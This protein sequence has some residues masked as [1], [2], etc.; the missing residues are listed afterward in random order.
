MIRISEAV[1]AGHPDKF[2]D[3]VA[4]AVI[5]ACM[6][7]DEDAYGQVEVAAWSDEVWL[8]G[9][10]CTRKP[11]T[12]PIGDIVVE[13][14]QAV[15]YTSGNWVDASRYR[16]TDAICRRVDEP[17][18]WTGKVNDQ[19]VVIGWAGYDE[20]V[21]YL[22]P[23]HFLAQ[24]YRGAMMDSCRN[25]YLEGQ[26]PD[27]KLLVRLKEQSVGWE[28]EHVLVTLQQKE[29]DTFMDLCVAVEKTLEE[30]YGSIRG[31]NPKW[32]KP[33]PEVR[34]MINPNGP[35]INGGSDGDNGQTGRKLAMDFYGPR[36]PIGGG[37]LSGKHLSHIDRIGAY[38]AREAAVR[39]VRSG[40]RE[41]LVRVAYAPNTSEPLD[42]SYQMLGRGERE[43]NAFF[44]LLEMIAR[45]S[46]VRITR[47][48]AEGRHFFDMGLPWNGP[49]MG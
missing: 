25:G 37:A 30:A 22:P 16:V 40:A 21:R 17:G 38:A 20:K 7:I 42:V 33:W 26:G 14:G 6:R 29:S 31:A 43:G 44:E 18:V 24:A 23:E 2:C 3:Q 11:M 49:D 39:A 47:E 27:G 35:L 12:K 36:V 32:A 34:L 9:G 41:C 1:L 13:T 8:N 19:S 10:I 15:G 45:Y 5:A 46:G 28:L 48:L 4:D